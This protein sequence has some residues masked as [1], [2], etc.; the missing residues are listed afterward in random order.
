MKTKKY[1]ILAILGIYLLATVKIKITKNND[2]YV[3]LI[4]VEKI[5]YAFVPW[6]LKKEFRE[7]SRTHKY[8]RILSFTKK[9]LIFLDDK[10]IY[11]ITLMNNDA[12][13]HYFIPDYDYRVTDNFYL[14]VKNDEIT[15]ADMLLFS[16][17][18]NNEELYSSYADIYC[19]GQISIREYPNKKI[20]EL[21]NEHSDAKFVITECRKTKKN[22]L[23][24]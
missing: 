23:D 9:N 4:P 11:E 19:D 10:T 18:K 15:N 3:R 2:V 13:T 16:I 24:E 20:I 6:K 17:I 8:C 5:R 22:S 21:L 14:E 7:Y 1:I 12:D